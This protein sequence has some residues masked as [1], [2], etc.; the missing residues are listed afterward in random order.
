M[1][2][3][4]VLLWLIYILPFAAGDVRDLGGRAGEGSY[5]DAYTEACRQMRLRINRDV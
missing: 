2:Y 5:K 3:N 4:S 1:V